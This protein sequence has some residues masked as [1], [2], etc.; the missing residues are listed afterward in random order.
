MCEI[1][2]ITCPVCGDV[3]D[4]T[5]MSCFLCNTLHHNDCWQFNGGCATFGCKEESIRQNRC[6][7]CGTQE[8]RALD[9]AQTPIILKAYEPPR[10]EIQGS[11]FCSDCTR[12]RLAQVD[13]SEG[14]FYG[15]SAI[16]FILWIILIIGN[17]P[18]L[19]TLLAAKASAVLLP[20]AG[21]AS[22]A[23]GVKKRRAMEF[24]GIPPT[25]PKLLEDNGDFKD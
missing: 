1:E 7:L 15:I 9:V 19:S 23:M 6:T 24:P 20:L 11:S 4:D 17:F 10:P 3:D 16:F 21:V 2:T 14:V 5:S 13:S 18:L 22:F 8:T 25:N 12:D